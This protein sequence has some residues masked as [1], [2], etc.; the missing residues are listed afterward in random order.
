MIAEDAAEVDAQVVRDGE[1]TLEFLQSILADPSILDEIPEGA[2]V[3][4][5]PDDDPELVEA[6]LK[7]AERS[8][9]RGHP[10]YVRR[11]PSRK[12]A[13]NGRSPRM[14]DGESDD[15]GASR[16]RVSTLKDLR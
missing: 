9:Q 8:R 15:V 13:E 12:A 6:N 5:L 16:Q 11:T 3:Y 10:V 4:L 14:S 1:W 2:A 7:G